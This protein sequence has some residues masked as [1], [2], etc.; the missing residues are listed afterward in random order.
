[1]YTYLSYFVQSSNVSL[2]SNALMTYV[3]WSP[4]WGGVEEAC[5]SSIGHKCRSQVV[6]RAFKRCY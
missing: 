5:T 6:L 4:F 2:F 1:M 3:K